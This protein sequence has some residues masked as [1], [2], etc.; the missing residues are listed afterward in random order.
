MRT[1]LV[2]GA[3][4]VS[5]GCFSASFEVIRSFGETTNSFLM[6]SLATKQSISVSQ[7]SQRKRQQNETEHAGVFVKW[8]LKARATYMQHPNTHRH[9]DTQS[10]PSIPSS[11][12]SR[13]S[14][15]SVFSFRSYCNA[16]SI[17]GK[18]YYHLQIYL[19]NILQE[20]RTQ[21]S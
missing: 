16:T 15:P 2:S 21:H 4:P 5:Q 20:S 19:S 18:H 14:V 3:F 10:P 17:I 12:F 8:N 11:F 9:T 1:I 7:R 13:S 6:K